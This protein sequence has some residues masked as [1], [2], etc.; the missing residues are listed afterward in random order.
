MLNSSLRASVL[1]VRSLPILSKAYR[2][3][4]KRSSNEEEDLC[5]DEEE[6]V[7]ALL[8]LEEEEMMKLEED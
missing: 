2:L 8:D 1:N 7:A 3:D 4:T 6:E 5:D